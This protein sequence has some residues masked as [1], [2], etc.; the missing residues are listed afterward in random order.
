VTQQVVALLCGDRRERERREGVKKSVSFVLQ[1]SPYKA[2]YKVSSSPPP[3]VRTSIK[4]AFVTFTIVA[5]KRKVQREQ[6]TDWE[7]SLFPSY[8]RRL[9]MPIVRPRWNG[10]RSL[11]LVG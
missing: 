11:L 10:R 7:G 4:L 6:A 9:L 1:P 3:S 5:V 2:G 8:R